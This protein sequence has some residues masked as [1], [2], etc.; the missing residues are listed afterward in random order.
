MHTRKG[1]KET[2]QQLSFTHLHT[3]FGV[4][5]RLQLLRRSLYS[6]GLFATVLPSALIGEVGLAANSQSLAYRP[7]DPINNPKPTACSCTWEPYSNDPYI[8]TTTPQKLIK[9]SSAAYCPKIKFPPK[10]D[11][12]SYK[13]IICPHYLR[14]PKNSFSIPIAPTILAY[15]ARFEG[16]STSTSKDPHSAKEVGKAAVRGIDLVDVATEGFIGTLTGGPA[17]GAR[18]AG[19]EVVKGLIKGTVD[20][21]MGCHLGGSP[22]RNPN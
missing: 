9:P 16:E 12:S 14:T 15:P 21:C 4:I 3:I 8:P 7:I 19:G 2:L 10:Y 13:P 6:L 20:H 11:S 17:N 22:N 5:M 1:M 18:A